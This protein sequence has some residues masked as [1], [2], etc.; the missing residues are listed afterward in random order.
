MTPN[1]WRPSWY[2]PDQSA[3]LCLVHFAEFFALGIGQGVVQ[4]LKLGLIL[5]RVKELDE[6]LLRIIICLT[7]I[8]SRFVIVVH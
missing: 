3:A 7:S 2:D 1:L 6:V 4:T 8:P 5:H